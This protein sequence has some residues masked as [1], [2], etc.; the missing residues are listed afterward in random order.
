M[1]EIMF[2]TIWIG[3]NRK[4]IFADLVSLAA[5]DG[6]SLPTHVYFVF[7]YYIAMSIPSIFS[8]RM[9]INRIVPEIDANVTTCPV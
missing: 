9:Q 4:I 8:V 1:I 2:T 6:V 5:R 3:I 7:L